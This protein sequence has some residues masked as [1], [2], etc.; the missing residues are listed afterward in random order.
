MCGIAGIAGPD[1][2]KHRDA[3]GRMLSCMQHRGPDGDGIYIAPS[4]DCV[5]GHRRLSIIDLSNLSAQPF[6]V[7]GAGSL[8]YNGE[9]YNFLELKDELQAQGIRFRSAGDTEV[10]LQTLLTNPEQGLQRLNAMFALGF[11]DERANYLILA[12]DYYGQKPL[13]Y[14]MVGQL[15]VFASEV[16]ALLASGLIDRKL[17]GNSVRS[18][19]SYGAVQAPETIIHGVFAL[20]PDSRLVY[21]DGQTKISRLSQWD[22]REISLE[23]DELRE[24]LGKAARRHLISDANVAI[25]LSGGIDSSAVVAAAS[26]SGVGKISTL[27]LTFPDYEQYSEAEAARHVAKMYGTDHSEVPMTRSQIELSAGEALASMDQPTVDGVNTFL[28]SRAAR[29]AGFKVALSGLG[30]DEIFGGYSSFK[31]V[32]RMLRLRQK[33]KLVPPQL[34]AA[35]AALDPHGKTVNKIADMTAAPADVVSL[36]LCR[37]R[38]FTARQ[39]DA[40]LKEQLRTGRWSADVPPSRLQR[41]TEL[42]TGRST[43]DSISRLEISLYMEQMLLRDSDVMGMANS[44]EIRLPLLDREFARASLCIPA[45]KRIVNPPSKALMRE[46]VAPW[47]P[48]EIMNKPKQGFV[49]PF[50]HWLRGPL[51]S[52]METGLQKVNTDSGLQLNT[53]QD[54]WKRFLLNPAGTDWIR[55][56]SLFV[57]IQY[58]ETH[59]LHL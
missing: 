16:R 34:V 28:V 12:R 25:F 14:A 37:R 49:L 40:L 58:L 27:T 13:Y 5:L 22:D 35:V 7:P 56:W 26:K 4:N 11:W 32:P 23:L 44:L 15:I 39:V 18:Y 17:N 33:L 24:L 31:D 59:D 47:L 10:V 36:Y 20:E 55:P 30:G 6:S 53:I 29:E 3:V 9:C 51:K 19:L 1:A 43:L 54:T 38:I 8:T 57:L 41:V 50:E 21:R 45:S 42:S 46:L 48:E 52:R 2:A